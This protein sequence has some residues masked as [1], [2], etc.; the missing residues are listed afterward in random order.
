MLRV[1]FPPSHP[2]TVQKIIRKLIFGAQ[3][4][5]IYIL[6]AVEARRAQ[7]SSK[8][9]QLCENAVDVDYC[10]SSLS[11]TRKNTLTERKQLMFRK[12]HQFWVKSD[13]RPATKGWPLPSIMSPHSPNLVTFREDDMLPFFLCEIYSCFLRKS[14]AVAERI[15]F[16]SSHI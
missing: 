7:H 1:R 6:L 2:D 5:Y 10:A 11:R 15:L 3:K 4:M 16:H 14:Y 12:L 9:G 8:V 13:R